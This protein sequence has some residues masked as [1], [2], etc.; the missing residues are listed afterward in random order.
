MHRIVDRLRSKGRSKTKNIVSR[1]PAD[2]LRS[3]IQRSIQLL[4]MRHAAVFGTQNESY[5]F[6][7]LS[8]TRDMATFSGASSLFLRQDPLAALITFIS[9]ESRWQTFQLYAL[10]DIFCLLYRSDQFREEIWPLPS[11]SSLYPIN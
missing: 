3:F 9:T 10:P 8:S 1:R 7:L 11:R 4:R 6:V 5:I 2:V